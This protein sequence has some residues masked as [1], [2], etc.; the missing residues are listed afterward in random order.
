[1]RPVGVRS[2]ALL[3]TAARLEALADEVRD[4]AHAIAATAARA[5]PPPVSVA[6][7]LPLLAQW[8]HLE[9]ETANVVGPAGAWGEGV[10]LGLKHSHGH[11]LVEEGGGGLRI[12]PLLAAAPLV[13][14]L[15]QPDRC[16]R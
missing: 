4:D 1:M 10:A 6:G 13:L 5:R 7:D 15:E 2:D 9:G 3:A 11:R 14:L 16:R 8:A 12:Q